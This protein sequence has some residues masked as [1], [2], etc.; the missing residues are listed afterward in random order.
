MVLLAVL[1]GA[2][3]VL[4][5]QTGIMDLQTQA[6]VVVAVDIQDQLHI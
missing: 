4:E 2:V 3:K 5:A 6:A 1:A